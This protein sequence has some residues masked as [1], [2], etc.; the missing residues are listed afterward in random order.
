MYRLY[1]IIYLNMLSHT[2]LTWMKEYSTFTDTNDQAWGVTEYMEQRYVIS[3]QKSELY[4]GTVT[5][6][7]DVIRLQILLAKIGIINRI[8]NRFKNAEHYTI[9]HMRTL[10][11]VTRRQQ[12]KKVHMM[13]SS[14][15][16]AFPGW[17]YRHYFVLKAE[18]GKN[19]TMQCTLW[20]HAV[21]ILSLSKDSTSNFMKHYRQDQ[22]C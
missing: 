15:K 9:I 16:N 12:R 14:S 2:F 19:I 11:H 18:S 3:I 13:T 6:K 22:H 21:K 4:S 8:T 10:Q 5:N 7:E 1:R 20:L 17:K